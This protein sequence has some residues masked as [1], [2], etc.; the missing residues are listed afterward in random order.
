MEIVEDLGNQD[1]EENNK[2]SCS[3]KEESSDDE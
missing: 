2:F 1:S 3:I